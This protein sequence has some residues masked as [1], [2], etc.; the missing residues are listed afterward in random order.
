MNE[1]AQYRCEDVF[2][3]AGH[4]HDDVLHF[5]YLASNEEHDA[6]RY[7]PRAR[8]RAFVSK[9]GATM[10]LGDAG[11]SRYRTQGL[12]TRRSSSLPRMTL[13]NRKGWAHLTGHETE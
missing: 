7:I 5:H 6:H 11:P 13:R 9:R 3:K 8:A 4:Q 2:P 10:G 1:M 12:S